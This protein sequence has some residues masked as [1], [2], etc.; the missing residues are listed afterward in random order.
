L[1]FCACGFDRLD[2][3]LLVVRLGPEAP[4]GEGFRW[5]TRELPSHGDITFAH[6]YSRPSPVHECLFLV[7]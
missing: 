1:P 3:P 2:S 4:R 7:W 5:V 6:G